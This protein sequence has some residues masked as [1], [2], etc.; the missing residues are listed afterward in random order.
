MKRLLF[1][2]GL[3]AVLYFLTRRPGYVARNNEANK[4]AY[5]DAK[6]NWSYTEA[7]RYN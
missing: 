6:P 7:W 3:L 4:N 5:R 1:A 2:L